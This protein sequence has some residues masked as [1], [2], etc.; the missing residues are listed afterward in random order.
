MSNYADT[1]EKLRSEFQNNEEYPSG[2]IGWGMFLIERISEL[3]TTIAQLREQ[4]EAA[5][6]IERV[7]AA[8]AIW[9]GSCIHW[10][11]AWIKA[12]E[13]DK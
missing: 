5:P 9:K 1:L 4:L 12:Q 6:D 3:D 10:N 13:Q 7:K 8:W 2:S 11:D